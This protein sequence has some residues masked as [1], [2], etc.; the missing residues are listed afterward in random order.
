[1]FRWTVLLLTFAYGAVSCVLGLLHSVAVV[2]AA[3]GPGLSQGAAPLKIQLL[4]GAALVV[5]AGLLL[6]AAERWRLRKPRGL[7]QTGVALTL[8]LA[9][10]L[11]IYVRRSDSKEALNLM[12]AGFIVALF[13]GLGACWGEKR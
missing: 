12:V 8:L 2:K 10:L 11:V 6:F 9:S 3:T 1:M 13:L 5:P 7:M 4:I